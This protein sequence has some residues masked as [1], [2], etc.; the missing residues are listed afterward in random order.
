MLWRLSVALLWFVSI[1][2]GSLAAVTLWVILGFPPEPRKSDADTLASQFEARKGESRGDV[3]PLNVTGAARSDLGRE[4]GAQGRSEAE[5]ASRSIAS[6]VAFPPAQKHDKGG[7]S[8]DRSSGAPNCTDQPIDGPR[9]LCASGSS[10]PDAAEPKKATKELQIDM[11]AGADQPQPVREPQDRRPA[12]RQQET[13][14]AL[15]DLRP[16]AQCSV[17]LCATTY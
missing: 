11:G 3:G 8:A 15:T 9:R 13:P 17:D 4:P 1:C 10:S 16:R 6:S 5:A 12:A 14:T 2:A 7:A